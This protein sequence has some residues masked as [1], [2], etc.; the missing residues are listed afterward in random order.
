M[1][2]DRLG[3][4]SRGGRKRAALR[5]REVLADGWR[6]IK[7]LTVVSL[8]AAGSPSVPSESPLLTVVVLVSADAVAIPNDTGGWVIQ[9]VRDGISPSSKTGPPVPNDLPKDPARSALPARLWD[10]ETGPEAVAC[11]PFVEMYELCLIRK[12]TPRRGKP[13]AKN[14]PLTPSPAG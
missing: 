7:P 10:R 12:K 2:G 5:Q 3:R 11:T 14:F 9:L 6:P 1:R 4:G 8:F 13:P